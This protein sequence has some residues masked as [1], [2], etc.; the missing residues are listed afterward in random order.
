MNPGDYGPSE[1]QR[2][3]LEASWQL[4][5]DQPMPANSK[6]PFFDSSYNSLQH[7][8]C[9]LQRFCYKTWICR[10]SDQRPEA[11]LSLKH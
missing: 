4:E 8:K 10:V 11:V 9:V 6:V 3:I 5:N 7:F 1:L 2:E